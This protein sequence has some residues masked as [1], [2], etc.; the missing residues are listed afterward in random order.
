MIHLTR[1]INPTRQH[2]DEW[3]ELPDGRIAHRYNILST[4]LVC[5][6]VWERIEHILPSG[7]NGFTHQEPWG[8][9]GDTTGRPLPPELDALPA[10]TRERAD[11]VAAYYDCL[12]QEA[13]ATVRELWPNDFLD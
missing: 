9:L 8:W 11:A 12:E 2:L 13:E 5:Y 10:M 3:V 7:Y 1:A 4:P 6:A